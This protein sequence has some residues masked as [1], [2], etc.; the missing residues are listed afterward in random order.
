MGYF[1]WANERIKRMDWVDVGF[2]KLSCM[3]VALLVAKLWPPIL[4]LAW[5]WYAIIFVLA[6]IKPLYTVYKK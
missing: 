4:S 2:V 1:E 3:A 5:Y 6:A